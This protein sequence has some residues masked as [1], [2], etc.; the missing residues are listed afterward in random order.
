MTKLRIKKGD[1]VLILAGKDKGK[2]GEVIKVNT[3]SSRVTVEGIN[4]SKKHIKNQPNVTNAG[5]VD[6]ESPIHISNVM[7][8]HP[9]SSNPGRVAYEKLESGKYNRIVKKS[10]RK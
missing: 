4:I 1:Q 8:V 5:I 7:Y 3:S 9:E 6:T 10:N 2:K